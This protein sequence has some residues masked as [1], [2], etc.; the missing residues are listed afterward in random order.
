MQ[1]HTK[2]V[3]ICAGEASGDN[4]GADLARDLLKKDPSLILRGMGG[5]EM[6]NAG[7][8]ILFPYDD[9]AVIGLIEVF[10]QFKKIKQAFNIVKTELQQNKPDVVIFIDYPGFNLRMA[11]IAK[12]AGIKVLYY[13]SPKIWAWKKNRIHTIKRYVDHMA[14]LFSFEEKIY[15]QAG[16]PAT[17]IGHPLAITAHANK[18]RSEIFQD[19]KLNPNNSVI[20]LMPGSRKNEIKRMSPVLLDCILEIHKT[21]PNTQFILPIAT[22]IK[23]QSLPIALRNKVKIVHK[24][25]YNA[26]SISKAAIVT[27]GTAT[28][29]VALMQVPM[30]IIYKT[31]AITYLVAKY[32][33]KIPYIGL[34]NII[35]QKCVAPEFIQ[36]NM[37]AN[38]ICAYIL[39]LMNDDTFHQQQK[40]EISCVK[41]QLAFNKDN[42]TVADITF[43]LLQD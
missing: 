9:I 5:S 11:K 29:E 4:L 38:N 42:K 33:I 10:T 28:L 43:Q 35:A 16:V 7:V 41:Q 3:F 26:L 2:K 39:K 18:S 1:A 21:Y 20:T 24:A 32:V 22:C 31:N 34:C 30:A 19:F 37:T 13:V 17:F 23:E 15:H 6:Q 27:S 14:L 25:L 36:H 8:N 40:N 12:Q